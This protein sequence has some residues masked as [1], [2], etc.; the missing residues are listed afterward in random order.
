MDAPKPLDAA[1]LRAALPEGNWDLVLVAETGSTNADVRAAAMAGTATNG[2]VLVAERQLAGRGRRD[3]SWTSAPGAG[4]TFS[5]LVRPDVVPAAQW[6]WL[7][8]L[9]GLAVAE[10][11]GVAAGVPL[12][13]KWPNDVLDAAGGKVAGILVERIDSPSGPLAA[14]GIGL[15]V[16]TATADLPVERASSLAIAGATNLDRAQVLGGVL[17]ALR[18]RYKAWQAV[19]GDAAACGLAV[20]YRAASATLGTDVRVDL[21]G[22]A[23]LLGRA[24]GLGPDGSLQLR[25]GDGLR[26]VAAGDVTHVRAA[27]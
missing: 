12:T 8:L 25:T 15:N 20:A 14:I 3:R 23:V 1:E 6:G 27:S 9:A 11:A 26:T 17:A 5:V 19:A 22:E 24:E 4:L 16:S 21:P 2:R 10:G 18:A 7:P 13:L